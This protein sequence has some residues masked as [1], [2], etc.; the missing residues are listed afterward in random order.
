MHSEA[1]FVFSLFCEARGVSSMKNPLAGTPT[2]Y[3]TGSAS[4]LYQYKREPLAADEADRLQNACAT[5]TD[6]LVVWTLLDTGLRVNELCTLTKNSVQWQERRVMVY[7]KGGPYGKQT[8]RR[9]VPLTERAFRLLANV[10]ERHDD[11]PF[12][13]R[14]AQQIVKAVA[15]RAGLAKPVTPHSLR[16]TFAVS[17]LQRGINLR[18]LQI[19][20]GHDHIATTEIY[21][22]LSPEDVI[23]EFESKWYAPTPMRI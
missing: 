23:R 16:H 1:L 7:G 19:L 11:F 20:L 10:F 8:K 6:R 14:R 22:R 2:Q 5:F 4:P 3:R 12:G 13:S 18:A 15:N 9:I 21:L 17:C